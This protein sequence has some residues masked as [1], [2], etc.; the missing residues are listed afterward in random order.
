VSCID[1]GNAMIDKGF[2]KEAIHCYVTAIRL[3]PKFSAAHSN[4]GSVFKEQGKLQ[5]AIAHYQEAIKI[6]PS[7]ADAFS[8]LGELMLCTCLLHILIIFFL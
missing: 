1:T 4:L 5:Q 8:N 6:D 3:M 7:F 2:I